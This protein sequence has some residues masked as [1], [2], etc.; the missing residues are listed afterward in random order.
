MRVDRLCNQLFRFSVVDRD[1]VI[2][3]EAQ[4]AIL[5]RLR[6]VFGLWPRPLEGHRRLH[7]S[8]QPGM[9]Q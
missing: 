9:V 4:I 7:L 8:L 6:A 5:Q 2:G 3:G 1:E